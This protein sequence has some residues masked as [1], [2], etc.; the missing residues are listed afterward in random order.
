MYFD[1]T[2]VTK[3]LEISKIVFFDTAK[4]LRTQQTKKNECIDL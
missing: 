2:A 1:M 3:I 4:I